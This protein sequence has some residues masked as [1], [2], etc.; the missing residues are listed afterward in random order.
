M[1]QKK[2]NPKINFLL[3]FKTFFDFRV[4]RPCRKIQPENKGSTLR[5]IEK[6]PIAFF[7]RFFQLT[8]IYEYDLRVDID[9]SIRF[10]LNRF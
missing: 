10:F 4:N 5:A 7:I 8:E 9:W 3:I 1:A 6:W 2:K